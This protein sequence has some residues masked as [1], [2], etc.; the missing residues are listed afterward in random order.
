MLNTFVLEI[1]RSIQVSATV[2]FHMTQEIFLN[3]A[4]FAYFYNIGEYLY[5]LF[6]FFIVA[7]VFISFM[8]WI[9]TNK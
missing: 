3:N 2:L 7:I 4:F 9:L 6:A 1:I 5:I 8:K